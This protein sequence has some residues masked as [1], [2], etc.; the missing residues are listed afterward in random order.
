MFAFPL[1][2]RCVFPFVVRVY[3]VLCVIG[4][5]V[6]RWVL[7]VVGCVCSCL[8]VVVC[9]VLVLSGVVVC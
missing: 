4:Y 9:C 5:C 8:M 7:L 1:L 6:D 3:G 2:V